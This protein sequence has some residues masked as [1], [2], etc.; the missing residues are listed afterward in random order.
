MNECPIGI[1]PENRQVCSAGSCDHCVE[2]L[3]RREQI[4]FEAWANH[5]DLDL[6]IGRDGMYREAT[7]NY[8]FEGWMAKAASIR[9]G[10]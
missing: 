3:V 10:E 8:L 9:R 5:V 2:D 7:V 4:K 6:Q 1:S